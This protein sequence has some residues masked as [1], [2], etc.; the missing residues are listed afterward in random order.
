[1]P[2]NE[3]IKISGLQFSYDTASDIDAWTLHI[4]DF[5]IVEK[6]LYIISGNNMSGKSTFLNI[7]A[8]VQPLG[9][10]CNL[11]SVRG[12]R[13][14]DV[15]QLRDI[16]VFL[17]NDDNMFPEFSIWD[18]I[19]VT[20][21]KSDRLT[22]RKQRESCAEFLNKSDIF[23]GRSLD[24]A[25]GDLSTGGIALVKF[26]RAHVSDSAI[27]I[28]DELTS[29]LDDSR[30]AFFLDRILEL[31]G[32]GAAVLIVSHSERDRSYLRDRAGRFGI[33]ISEVA[34]ERV[35]NISELKFNV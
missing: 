12:E 28:V 4:R 9:G 34:I 25:L 6:K 35:G 1:M 15:E 19:R 3:L 11:V 27:V 26:C 31:I 24:A 2:S 8:G 10:D 30:A 14:K 22:E 23:A 21:Q 32:D 33:D 29:Y 13:I 20:L 16:S 5:S 18:N 7:I 17:S